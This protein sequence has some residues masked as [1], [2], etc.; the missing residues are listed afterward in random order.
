MLQTSLRYLAVVAFTASFSAASALADA[1]IP[2]DWTSVPVEKVT[3]FYP[4][5]S[6][7]QWLHSPE[8]PGARMV[9]RGTA[10]KRCHRD[11]ER[12][13]GN[14]IVSGGWL[15]PNPIDGKKGSLQLA[16]QAAHDEENLYLR[17]RWKT[18][19]ERP[20]V[21]H[22]YMRYD[23]QAWAFYGGPRSAKRV[24]QGQEPP[25]YEDRLAIMID[26]GDVQ[27]FAEQGCWLSCHNGMRDMPGEPTSEAVRSHP[28]LGEGGLGRSDVRKYL[29]DSRTD[30]SAS[31][32]KVKSPEALAKLK[33]KGVFLDLMQW[34][35][36]RSN[37]VD[38]ADDGF[39]L[40]YRLF[41]EGKNP[42]SWNVDRDSMT[43]E[44]MFDPKKVGRKSL[45]VS[46]IETGPEPAALIREENSARYDPDA[47]WKEGDVLPG[48]LLSRVDARGSAADNTRVAGKWED[49][50]WIVT[51]IRPLD[52]GHDDDITLKRGNTYTFGFAVHD[53]NVTTRF[54]FVSF[55][56][57]VGIGRGGDVTA[58]RLD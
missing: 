37:P 49:G 20:G 17:F 50:S 55:P 12:R 40:G 14:D 27:R 25:L 15:E 6:S 46:D 24:R 45:T 4:G 44:F 19:A 51:W 42:F 18:Q 43:P 52:T 7:F 13:M 10:C 58:V 22:N 36:A 28:Y 54:H 34:R 47:G 33:E 23:G 41:D 3:L 21:M 16:V 53:D 5:Q 30:T 29:P 31:W 1:T 9:G 48:R 26:D 2:V 11:S 32:D 35:A 57:V 38:M 39:V 56:V 8:H